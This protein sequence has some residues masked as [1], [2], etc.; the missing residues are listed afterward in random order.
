MRLVKIEDDR[1]LDVIV[2]DDDSIDEIWAAQN[3]GG[4]WIR[5]D[6]IANGSAGKNKIIDRE[7]DAYVYECPGEN[8]VL[9]ETSWEWVQ[10][11]EMA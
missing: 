9:D 1:V 3:N 11:N 2:S 10:K 6:S 5:E 8:Y 4:M 7:L